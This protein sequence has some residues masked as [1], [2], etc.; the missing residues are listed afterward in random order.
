MPGDAPCPTDSLAARKDTVPSGMDAIA[1]NHTR[2]KPEAAA[3]TV[4]QYRKP[5]P[6]QAFNSYYQRL[7][8]WIR[9]LEENK[10]DD[11]F[12][13]VQTD[14]KNPPAYYSV[15]QLLL[16]G[17]GREQVSTAREGDLAEVWMAEKVSIPSIDGKVF[18]DYAL[19]RL[20]GIA[21]L[22]AVGDTLSRAELVQVFG[23][24]NP[25]G[26]KVRPE[27]SFRPLVVQSFEPTRQAKI[28]EMGHIRYIL[29]KSLVADP[30][31]YLIVDKGI[32]DTYR[33]G[34]AVAFWERDK[35]DKGLA[36]RLLGRGLV[37]R[38]DGQWSVVLV[39]ELY[40][41]SHR[42]DEG[43]LVSITHQPRK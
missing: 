10:E 40:S 7:S 8:P 21:R 34:T 2:E 25:D 28:S 15:G 1:R 5:A 38:S 29:E 27:T 19:M 14:E 12:F 26:A 20:A 18:T 35:R 32:E 11:S 33:P 24:L 39:R 6:P 36:P 3:S 37:T 16:L 9:T 23:K 17:Y 41:A 13:T 43:H 4:Y 22:T 31:S 30:Y 42:I